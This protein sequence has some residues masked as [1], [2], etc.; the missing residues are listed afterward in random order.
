MHMEEIARLAIR[1]L[2]GELASPDSHEVQEAQYALQAYGVAAI[3]GVLGAM[4]QLDAFGQLCAIEII[5]A[6][7]KAQLREIAHPSVAE[8]LIPLL[9]SDSE[10]VREWSARALSG[11]EA[12]EA[13]P[14][15]MQ[16]EQRAKDAH[17]PPDWGERVMYREALTMLGVRHAVIPASIQRRAIAIAPFLVCWA[18]AD[19]AQVIRDLKAARQAVL[20]FQIWRREKNTLFRQGA[21]SNET[22]LDGRWDDVLERLYAVALDA[23]KQVEHDNNTVVTIEWIDENDL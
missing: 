14:M 12:H 3:P 5:E 7:E 13:I 6:C 18:A 21:W 19:V 2:V 20:Y 23:A 9:A 10:V 17:I 4:P 22:R 16:A 15:L 11:L 1:R 8:C